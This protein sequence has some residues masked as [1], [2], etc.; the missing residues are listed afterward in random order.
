VV[1]KRLPDHRRRAGAVP[2]QVEARRRIGDERVRRAAKARD[3]GIAVPVREVHEEAA[4]Q[5][6]VRREREAEQTLLA[7]RPHGRRDIEKIH[8]Q[9]AAI[10]H[11]AN[12]ATLFD[13]ELDRGIRGIL[14]DGDRLREAR[15]VHART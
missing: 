13:D 2:S 4:G 9:H 11:Y 6:R 15:R 10:A 12:A 7:P 3:D 14:D 1:R 8:R 5:P